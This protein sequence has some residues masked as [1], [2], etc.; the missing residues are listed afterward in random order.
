MWRCGDC[1]KLIATTTYEVTCCYCDS[2]NV[3][4]YEYD[5]D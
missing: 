2:A 5:E 3:D 1:D 4:Y